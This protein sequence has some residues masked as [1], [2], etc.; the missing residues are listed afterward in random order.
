M[1]APGDQD[2]INRIF[3]NRGKALEAFIRLLVARNAPWD[4]YV[5]GDTNAISESAKRG[6]K[7][8]VGKADC[9]QC[10]KGPS[11]TDEKF[12]DL[13]LI[14]TYPAG[15]QG[16]DPNLWS[17]F[18]GLC[19]QGHGPGPAFSMNNKFSRDGAYSDDPNTPL[20]KGIMTVDSDVGA[21]RT[22][23]LRNVAETAPY[24]HLGQLATLE[25]VVRYE[26]KGGETSGYI[27]TKDEKVKQLNLSDGEVADVVE[28]L[29]TLTGEQV[30]QQYWS[31]TP[32][33]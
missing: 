4:K 31:G 27:G 22:A 17:F 9:V 30:P 20:L 21:Y 3:V 19:D 13:G 6:A 32:N 16:Y 5:A 29:K 8:F 1:M 7:V 25:D 11:F 28:F 15:I 18:T 24:M 10:H 12:H 14:D 26:N 23:S 2:I 33:P